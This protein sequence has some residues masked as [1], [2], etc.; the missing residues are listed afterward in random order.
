MDALINTLIDGCI[1]IHALIDGCVQAADLY[2][3]LQIFFQKYPQFSKQD[4]Y[5]TGE[6]YAGK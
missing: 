5:I 6:S 4:F 3:A 2:S 1:L